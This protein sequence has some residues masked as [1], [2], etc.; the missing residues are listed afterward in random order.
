MKSP[1]KTCDRIAKE[2]HVGR[3]YVIKA[4]RYADGIDAANQVEP[5]IRQ[6][7]FSGAIC[8]EKSAVQAVALASPE[9]QAALVK[10]LRSPEVQRRRK[11]HSDRQEDQL[12]SLPPL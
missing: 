1:G 2:N 10:R 8:P 11:K 12:I 3:D 9:E 4:G 7:I 6:E 5:G